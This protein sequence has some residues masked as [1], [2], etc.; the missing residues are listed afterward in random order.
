[1]SIF[2]I[3][4]VKDIVYVTCKLCSLKNKYHS[5]AMVTVY[6]LLTSLMLFT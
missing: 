4:Y 5:V 6:M 3:L 2:L 1:M